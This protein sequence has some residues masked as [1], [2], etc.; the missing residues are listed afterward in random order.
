MIWLSQIRNLLRNLFH[1]EQ[2]DRDLDAEVRSYESFLQEESMAKGMNPD[3]A[4]RAARI[5]LG[6]PDQLKDEIRSAR[7]GAWLETFWQDLRFG[8]RMLR[9]NPG[10]SAIAIF[11]LALGI[12]ANTAIFSVVDATVLRPLPYPNSDQIVFITD[13]PPRDTIAGRNS[14]LPLIDDQ[15]QYSEIFSHVAS[16]APGESTI[17][18]ISQPEP[19]S[20]VMVSP[21]YFSLLGV[22]PVLGRDFLPGEEKPGASPVVI[23]SDSLWRR[24]FNADPAIIG[25]S[26]VLDNVSHI[27]IGVMPHNFQNPGYSRADLWLPQ[28][29]GN[30]Q[31]IARINDHS[32]LS[33]VRSALK[34]ADAALEGHGSKWQ[35]NVT[36]LRDEFSGD[37]QDDLAI[38]LACAGFVLLVACA[39]VANLL[40]ARG[41][42]R[43]LE[44]TV[45]SALGASR[46]RIGRQMLTE[47]VLL[48]CLGGIAGL[49]VAYWT[50]KVFVA[51]APVQFEGMDKVQVD[52][53][54]LFFVAIISF[55]TALLFGAFPA[56]RLTRVDL[57]G[58]LKE[59]YG[60]GA[61][62]G[63]RHSRA[64]NALVGSEVA[65]ALILMFGASLMVRSFL[66]LRPDHPGFDPSNKLSVVIRP[67]QWKYQTPALRLQFLDQLIGR[68]STLPNVKGVT[69]T[70]FFPFSGTVA[71]GRVF[72]NPGAAGVMGNSRSI[73]PNYFQVMDIPILSGRSFTVT[74]NAA[75]PKVA[76][77][78]R[79]MAEQIWPDENVL[80]KHFTADYKEGELEIVGVAGNTRI[81]GMN[82][83]LR[84]DFYVPMRQ[85]KPLWTTLII[86]TQS[87]PSNFVPAVRSAILSIDKDQ[88]L[89]SV[90]TVDEMLSTSVALQRFEALLVGSF[91]GI[92]LIL[93]SVGIYGVISY[94]V[95]QRSREL[96]IRI[97]LGATPGSVMR[98]ALRAT[99]VPVTIG[100]AFGWAASFGLARFMSSVLYGLSPTDAVSNIA[101]VAILCAVATTACYI[102]ARHALKIDPA[103]V[104]RC[105]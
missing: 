22:R 17:T 93:A 6:S 14:F 38:L 62:T 49:A 84:N 91:A 96:G 61:G 59:G 39:N 37:E 56:M 71:F 68:I 41:A 20:S 80:G 50:L 85:S 35:L 69:S 19:L 60:S 29:L 78:S 11:T 98:L 77:I 58:S 28:P 24:D 66:R 47:S 72:K 76:V 12:G 25:R 18:G 32:S 5:D 52:F 4:R 33:S 83:R 53:R 64:L 43:R 54:V 45:R 100:L 7:R 1:R 34:T 16:V 31:W 103:K 86:S 65:L 95:K 23:L 46:S 99:M 104:L 36:T 89:A 90:R 57:S 101:A 82:L 13:N 2:V 63:V 26:V 79:Q 55:F 44:I 73:S 81:S 9:K 42:G 94:S 75:A 105:E 67:A 40:L 74:D 92:A 21:A 88:A 10:F 30:D 70:D 3:A 97:A 48:G 8:A 51:A 27:V 87:D 102:P 15:R